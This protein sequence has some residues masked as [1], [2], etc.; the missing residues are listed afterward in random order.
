MT[1]Y[2]AEHSYLQS[3]GRFTDNIVELNKFADPPILIGVCEH[4][5]EISLSKNQS[6]FMAKVDDLVN[7]YTAYIRDDRHLEL[8]TQ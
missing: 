2:Y 3:F 7:R 5:I 6:Q 1:V 4:Q 8:F